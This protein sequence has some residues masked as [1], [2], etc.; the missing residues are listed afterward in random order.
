[1]HNDIIYYRL[2]FNKFFFFKKLIFFF[3][4]VP[5][6][7]IDP[8]SGSAEFGLLKKRFGT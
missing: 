3:E 5:E 2:I 6:S 8:N 4:K 1:L 7:E